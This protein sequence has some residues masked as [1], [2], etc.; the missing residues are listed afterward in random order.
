MA[1]QGT[2]KTEIPKGMNINP[3]GFQI[4]SYQDSLNLTFGKIKLC[5]RMH[6]FDDRLCAVSIDSSK[7]RRLEPS[8]RLP[9]G[10][11]HSVPD[12]EINVE[13]KVSYVTFTSL[14]VESRSQKN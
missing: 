11:E 9:T 8:T 2:K 10:Y 4:L 12:D 5:A 3:T 14:I 7:I 13:L 6:V 1:P